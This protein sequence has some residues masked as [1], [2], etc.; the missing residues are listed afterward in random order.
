MAGLRRGINWG[1]SGGG[2]GCGVVGSRRR[3]GW[4]RGGRGSC[5]GCG[6]NQMGIPM[7]T[8]GVSGHRVA[9][10]RVLNVGG[11]VVVHHETPVVEAF[12][13]D[14]VDW[15]GKV[16][17]ASA[18]DGEPGLVCVAIEAWLPHLMDSDTI[19]FCECVL[20][21]CAEGVFGD[22]TGAEH[23]LEHEL[24]HSGGLGIGGC[25]LV[26]E[27]NTLSIVLEGSDCS[28]ELLGCGCCRKAEADCEAVVLVLAA[29]NR[30]F[31]A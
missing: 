28:V 11:L 19:R 25:H 7:T 23:D 5:G 12:P 20:N 1:G 2:A 4:R 13:C 8:G 18:F 21:H 26:G 27:V 15:A 3:L 6:L 10:L 24:L 9:Q 22:D 17:L 29:H 31:Q 14:V 16:G 30:E